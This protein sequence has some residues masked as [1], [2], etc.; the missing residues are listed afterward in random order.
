MKGLESMNEFMTLFESLTWTFIDACATALTLGLVFWNCYQNYKQN[1]EIEIFILHNGV[2]TKLP[3]KLIRK[4]FTR[5]EIFGV[6]GAFDK[7]SKFTI[8]HTSTVV[9]FEDIEQIQKG[10]KNEICI[11]I[12]EN[13]KFDRVNI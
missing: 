1:Q 8:A 6:L 11:T 5:A 3:I 9:F 13:D 4:N 7:D 10:K 2:K 12:T